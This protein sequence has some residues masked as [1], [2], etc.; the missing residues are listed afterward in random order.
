MDGPI[1]RQAESTSL[2]P[3]LIHEFKWWDVAKAMQSGMDHLEVVHYLN[4]S[5]QI[6][7]AGTSLKILVHVLYVA[8]IL[9]SCV[10]Y[11]KCDMVRCRGMVNGSTGND[12][13]KYSV[14]ILNK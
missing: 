8:N 1:G 11:T 5:S 9:S 13:S 14:H 12:S 2:P 6:H 7:R 3:T 10:K 4:I